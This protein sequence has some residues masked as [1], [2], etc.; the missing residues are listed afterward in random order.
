[1]TM[2]R[3][4]LV[5]SLALCGSVSVAAQ[6]L[7]NQGPDDPAIPRTPASTPAAGTAYWQQRADYTIV[8]TLDESRQAVRAEGVLTYTNHSPDTLRELWLHQHLNAFRPGSRWSAVD[9]RENRDRFQ[10]LAEPD[11]GYERFTSAPVIGDVSVQP[12]YPLSP[13]STVLRLALPTPLP[14]GGRVAVRLAWEARPSTTVRRQGRRDRSY[15]FAQWYP[16]IAVYDRH[17]WKP[18][19]LVPAG[20]FYGEFGTFDVTLVLPA[21]QVV[22]ATGVVVEG[23]PGWARV[24]A[25][26]ALPH[27]QRN[28]YGALPPGPRATVPAGARAVRFVARD[29]HHFGWSVSPHFVYEGS[30]YVRPARAPRPDVRVW[31][32]VAV[33]VLY[34]GDAEAFCASERNPRACVA[35]A[36]DGWRADA[37]LRNGEE[38]LGWLDE[39]FGPYAYPQLTMLRRLDGGGTEFPMMMQN[40]SNSASLV[41]H[42]GAHIY[43]HGMLANNEWQSGWL[44]EGLASYVTA[45]QDGNVR[46]AI[47]AALEA[48]RGE[49][50]AAAARRDAKD[51]LARLRG[52][53]VANGTLDPIGLRADLFR[54]FNHYNTAVYRRAE[55]MYAALHDVL[56]D[57]TFRAFLRSYYAEWAFRHVDRWAMQQT[58]ERVSGQ[59]LGWFFDQWVESVGVV[60]YALRDAR[61]E[62]TADGWRTTVR[63]TRVGAY[64]HPMPVGVRA[65]GRWTVAR[66]DP[67]VDDAELS[68]VTPDR[69]DAVWLDPFGATDAVGAARAR[70]TIR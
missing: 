14:P 11:Y 51:E 12:E 52:V 47:A 25:N 48:S 38:T 63:L 45:W 19:A 20:E 43:A 18:N 7:P 37:A 54:S 57:A 1:M 21:D 29:V 41:T 9:A 66:G 58:A 32:T 5:A 60:E 33:H 61:V 4:L 59:D 10:S 24:A 50:A 55:E 34:R 28:A 22:G 3:V 30:R 40:G 65:G 53:A 16:R 68:I 8:A 15:D 27:E 2:H 17:G 36:R 64:R 46:V 26:G 42:E 62:Q 39:V 35:A 69:P 70:L 56:G 49:D 6:S 31:D 13:D 44:D 67:Q 23:D